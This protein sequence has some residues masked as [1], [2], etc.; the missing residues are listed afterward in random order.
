MREL[1]TFL[2]LAEEL[3]FGRTAKR[4]YL[5]QSRVSQIVRGLEDR[6]GGA[7]FERTSRRVALTA[8]GEQFRDDVRPAVEQLRLAVRR[9][10]ETAGGVHGLLRIGVPTYSMAGPRFTAVLREFEQRYPKCRVEVTEEFP[11]DFD[12][13]RRGRYDVLCQRLPIDEPDVTI[14]ATLSVDE[15]VLL[16]RTGHPLLDR[17]WATLEDLAGEVVIERS[18]IP[19]R[20]YA[21]YWPATTPSGQPIRRGPS[22]ATTSDVLQLVARGEIVH[23]TVA[24]F[25]TYYRHP[26]VTYV[27]L[28][29]LPAATNVL[30]WLTARETPAIRALSATAAELVAA[31]VK[32]D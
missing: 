1:E 5:T 3:H 25:S 2:V 20:V 6:L 15:R 14:G 22:I 17:G 9:G 18:G 27:P 7:L 11:G 30:V 26:E 16:V 13:L 28:R 24:S 10:R 32:P 29:G 21:E 19:E 8:L 23:P 12:R 4:L 31:G